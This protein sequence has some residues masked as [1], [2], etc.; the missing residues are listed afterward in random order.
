MAYINEWEEKDGLIELVGS[1]D[2][3][4]DDDDY[5]FSE[6]GFDIWLPPSFEKDTKKELECVCP[7]IELMRY[8]CR[9]EAGNEELANERKK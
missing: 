9:C 7:M 5:N 8:G 1:R 6:S 3:D 2:P 4:Y